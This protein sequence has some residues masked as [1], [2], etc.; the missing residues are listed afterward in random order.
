LDGRDS[1]DLQVV[2]AALAAREA[3]FILSSRS[4]LPVQALIEVCHEG[5]TQ[6]RGIVMTLAVFDVKRATVDWCGVGNVEA[7]LFH[8][9]PAAPF[10][11]EALVTRGGVIGYRLPSLKISTARVWPGDLLILATDGIRNGFVDGVQIQD[12]PQTIAESVFAQYRKDS[13][14]ALVLVARYNGGR[15]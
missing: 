10:A 11:C 8:A 14:D 6:T 7:V 5:L 13:D 4:T 15:P 2:D 3:A 12:D 9:D 1:G